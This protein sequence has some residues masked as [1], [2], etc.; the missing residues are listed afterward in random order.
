MFRNWNFFI[1]L[2]YL[3]L[4]E[5]E[6][7]EKRECSRFTAV[8]QRIKLGEA[9][10]L[11]LQK[12]RYKS[13]FSLQSISFPGRNGP[14]LV[15]SSGMKQGGWRLEW[16]D[17]WTRREMGTRG[18]VGSEGCHKYSAEQHR[19]RAGVWIWRNRRREDSQSAYLVSCLSTCVLN[20]SGPIEYI[21]LQFWRKQ[22]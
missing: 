11:E 16:E 5:D 22:L 19:M 13:G 3:C 14:W 15:C 1:S 8:P 2:Q 21:S 9:V 17:L 6:I 7:R 18:G 12:E 10:N 20:S 4:P